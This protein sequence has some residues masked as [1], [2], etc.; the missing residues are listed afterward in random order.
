MFTKPSFRP[1]VCCWLN[2]NGFRPPK[3]KKNEEDVFKFYAVACLR[4]YVGDGTTLRC[5]E[6]YM[7]ESY[8]TSWSSTSC[9]CSF[10]SVSPVKWKESIIYIKRLLAEITLFI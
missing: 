3:K 9:S 4:R 10:C 6:C 8:D 2:A 5:Y 7:A 1:F